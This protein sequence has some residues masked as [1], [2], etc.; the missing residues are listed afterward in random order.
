MN[1]WTAADAG[2]MEGKRI[3]VT[4]AN[5]GVGLEA[6]KVFVA[7]G[8]EVVMACRDPKRA[9]DAE[10]TLRA[11]HAAP[12]VR[13]LPLDLASLASVRAFAEQVAAL[14]PLDVLVNN[15]G[16]M[17]LPRRTTA[18]GFEMQLGTN[19][20]GHFA[21]TGLLLPTLEAAPAPRVVSVSSL[22]HRRG[23]MN[24]DDLMGERSYDRAATY[25][26]SKLANLL[27]THELEKRL[28]AAGKRT[29]AIGCHPGYS[30]T[31][32]QMGAAR[33]EGSALKERLSTWMNALLAQPAE[34]G[35]LATVR[36]AVDPQ[37][38]G[39]EYWGG[40]RWM[41]L[42]GHPVRITPSAESTDVA[43][44]KRLWEVSEQLTGVRFEGLS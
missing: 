27:F 24:F 22:L 9:A 23:R 14:G 39:G 3:V 19:H 7:R 18:D 29:A 17:D 33:M 1:D 37:V 20:L 38:K 44:M 16:V 25:A 31:Q 35:A 28:R 15:A 30:A 43:S 36:A 2:T 13:S 21:L 10:A 6:A 41:E 34:I 42:R 26:Q 4:G 5:S 40:V 12:K 8:A 11:Q 32:L